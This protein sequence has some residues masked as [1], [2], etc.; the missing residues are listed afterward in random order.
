[1]SKTVIGRPDPTE[2]AEFHSSY[3]DKVPGSDILTFLE[4]QLANGVATFRRIPEARGSF[5]YAPDKWTIKEVLGHIIDSE[6][7]FAYR[8]L[9]FARGDQTPL[10]G[11]DQDPWALNAN[12]S[13]LQLAEITDEFESVRR[14]TI[15]L[16]RH[17]DPAAWIR[18]G[19]AN[20]CQLT[21]RAIAYMIA[22]HTQHHL[23]IL[24]SRYQSN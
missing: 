12:Y 16:F 19:I 8:A 5:R 23:D 10:P 20:K 4:E 9:T 3:I 15:L 1:M 14:A 17:L 11:F 2:H 24:N 18:R 13:N 7:V 6:R 21:P 22:G